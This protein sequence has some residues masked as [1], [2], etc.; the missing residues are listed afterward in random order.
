MK[1]RNIWIICIII[2]TIILLGLVIGFLIL[3]YKDKQKESQIKEELEKKFIL[4]NETVEYGTE[5]NFSNEK[6][7]KSI[8][9][10]NDEAI[11]T[12]KFNEI[13]EVKFTE[14]NY[15]YYNTFLN[16][17]KKV[18]AKKEFIYIVE[19]TNKPII[20]GI[21]D[22][23]ITV[24]DDIDLKEGITAK[25][26]VDGNLEIL[27][28]GEVDI[29]TAGEYT[30]KISAKDKNNNITE[31]EYKV[32]VDKKEEKKTSNSSNNESTIN[33]NE[34]NNSSSNKKQ[35]QNNTNETRTYTYETDGNKYYFEEDRGENGNYGEKFSW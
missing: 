21:E 15:E 4:N 9:Y 23:H 18:E 1:K 5:I 3:N 24:G 16:K 14:V 34:T 30:V 7:I 22:K 25:D 29:N 35:E 28:D 8:I 19:D 26:A 2:V 13:G 11:D 20:E 10:F 12:Y 17:P 33:K 27:V 32:I 31:A 6:D